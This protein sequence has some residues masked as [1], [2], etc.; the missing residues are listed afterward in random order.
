MAWQLP[1]KRANG[2]I[3]QRPVVKDDHPTPT[4]NVATESGIAQ[5]S[6]G[7]MFSID[8][9]KIGAQTSWVN[10]VSS[11]VNRCQLFKV[12]ARDAG[13]TLQHMGRRIVA[14]DDACAEL[15]G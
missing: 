2:R 8:E 14:V 6:S 11:G 9:A 12:S 7:S 10:D 5:G 15:I 3:H 13:K 4:K 1:E